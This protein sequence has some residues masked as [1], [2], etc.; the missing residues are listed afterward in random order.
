MAAPTLILQPFANSGDVAVVP[1]TDPNAFVNFQQG[2]TPNYEINLASGN[3]AAKAVER[4]V[5]NWL[6]N[7]IT[8]NIQAQQQMGLPQWYSSMPG[9]YAIN[10][11][12][13]RLN[14]LGV[15]VPYRSLVANNVSDPL[16][17]AVNW[18]YVPFGHEILA[19]VPMP[20]GGANPSG[21]IITAATNFNSIPT[22][23][24]QLSS[25]AV[26]A[27]S[28]NSPAVIGGTTV[29]GLLEVLSWTSA[30]NTFIVQRYL[31]RNAQMFVRAATNGAWT[32]WRNF[33]TATAV[34]A[35]N[36]IKMWIGNP[37]QIPTVWGPG[38]HYCDGTNGTIDMRDRVPMGSSPTKAVGSVGGSATAVLSVANLPSHTHTVSVVDNGHAHGL[39]Q[40]AHSHGVADNGHSH[41]VSDNGHAHSMPAGGWC[42]S[43]QD[44][45][46]STAASGANQYGS[47]AAQSTNV[48]GT[49]ISIAG[50]STGIGIYGATIPISV[51]TGITGI[52]AA[53]NAT[54]S[55]TAFNVVNPYITVCYVQFTGT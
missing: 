34:F 44:N 54:G 35:I 10:A 50:N 11:T 6:F 38:W 49:N 19:S 52:T 17:N 41:G 48:A 23:T 5:Q 20:S 8:A 43:G 18:E 32:A 42:Q 16:T 47:R 26:A 1:Q 55:G 53:A 25:D 12:V 40:D 21:N 24:Y 30:P 4:P 51:N 29:A 27:A 2:Y 3:P 46:G 37:A 45:G 22:G 28:P 14:A 39:S 7:I 9:G 13:L 33:F 15:L 36:E 31:D